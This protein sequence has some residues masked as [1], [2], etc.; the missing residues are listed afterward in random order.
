VATARDL[1]AKGHT[2]SLG[3]SQINDR[4]LKGMGVTIQEVFDPCTNV[5]VGGK[6]LTDF[7]DRAVKKFGPGPGALQAALSAYNSGDWSRGARDGY[8]NL[9]YKQL[10]KP[11]HI[12]SERVVPRL[13]AATAAPA[14]G[15]TASARPA[16][17]AVAEHGRER[18]FTLKA[19]NFTVAEMN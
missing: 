16:A 17:N 12:R 4:N 7:Y 1:I 14:P 9:V 15:A 11:L 8:V 3:V 19:S 2:V 13:T 10:G 18:A 6:I 5:A